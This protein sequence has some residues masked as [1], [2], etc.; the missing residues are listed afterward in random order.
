MEKIKGNKLILQIKIYE[1]ILSFYRPRKGK[2]FTPCALEK[3]ATESQN[4]KNLAQGGKVSDECLKK[5][6]PEGKKYK[7]LDRS[8]VKKIED[9]L[10]EN[11][12]KDKKQRFNHKNSTEFQAFKK[13]VDEKCPDDYKRSFKPTELPTTVSS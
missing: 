10:V 13:C 5:C 7:D 1:I 6:N 8:E 9:C 3:C 11:K 12:C 2:R 4:L